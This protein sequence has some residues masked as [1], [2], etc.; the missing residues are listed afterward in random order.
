MNRLKNWKKEEALTW[1]A[2]H[3]PELWVSDE[4]LDETRPSS[5]RLYAFITLDE[6]LIIY[7]TEEMRSFLRRQDE[8]TIKEEIRYNTRIES[9]D[10]KNEGLN[11]DTD[12]MFEIDD[13]HDYG[14]DAEFEVMKDQLIKHI[15]KE[16]GEN[17]ELITK[18]MFH[19]LKDAEIGEI[20]GMSK[21]S[22]YRLKEAVRKVTE[23]YLK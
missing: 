3:H 23:K 22:I 9:Y 20:T 18:C 4:S 13:K 11:P 5:K 8:N 17:A 1:R 15:K 10:E 2:K 14:A 16:L 6:E 19:Q 12:R 21:G 7:T